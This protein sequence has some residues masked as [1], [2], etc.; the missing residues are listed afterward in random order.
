M[1]EQKIGIV[2]TFEYRFRY[3]GKTR[4]A[5]CGKWPV[6]SLRDVREVRDAKQA[7]VGVGTDPIEQRKTEKLRKRVEAVL[8]LEHQQAE[9]AR[10]AARRTGVYQQSCPVMFTIIYKLFVP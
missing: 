10:L 1:R 2:V 8:E 6:E 5:S 3:Q 9:L 4:T 7:L